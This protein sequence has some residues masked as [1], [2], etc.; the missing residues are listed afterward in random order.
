M[1]K[2]NPLRLEGSFGIWGALRHPSIII[3]SEVGKIDSAGA[4]PISQ[5]ESRRVSCFLRGTIAN[6]PARLKKGNLVLSP[7]GASWSP[8]SPPV[9][10][11]PL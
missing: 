10:A 3:G 2:E 5:G 1:A 9:G 11:P 4:D 6:D 7:G 8:F